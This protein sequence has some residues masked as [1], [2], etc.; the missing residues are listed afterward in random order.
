MIRCQAL[1]GKKIQC[2]RVSNKKVGEQSYCNQH[3]KMKERAIQ[4]AD[5]AWQQ[6]QREK[7]IGMSELEEIHLHK[8]F[9]YKKMGICYV[10]LGGTLQTNFKKRCIFT[11]LLVGNRLKREGIMSKDVVSQITYFLLSKVWQW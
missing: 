9:G 1:T 3:A 11:W 10:G 2:S 4:I 5:P 8:T 6:L 7:M